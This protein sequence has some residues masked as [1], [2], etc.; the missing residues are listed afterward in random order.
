MLKK[1]WSSKG[2][3]EVYSKTSGTSGG[4]YSAL[5]RPLLCG[6]RNSHEVKLPSIRYAL[7]LRPNARVPPF[8]L[9]HE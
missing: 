5:T 3:S 1:S 8:P 9:Q 7:S 2:R 6:Q 4:L